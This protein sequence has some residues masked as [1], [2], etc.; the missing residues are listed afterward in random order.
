MGR[1]I[2]WAALE[3]ICELLGVTDP[4]R[5]IHQLIVLRDHAP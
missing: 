3:L 5:L 2:D 1:R 4:E